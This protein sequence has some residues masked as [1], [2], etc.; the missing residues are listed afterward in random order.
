MLFWQIREWITKQFKEGST[1]AQKTVLSCTN[2]TRLEPA[3]SSQTRNKS[4]KEVKRRF[5][6]TL[7]RVYPQSMSH[8]IFWNFL[9][10]PVSLLSLHYQFQKQT[11]KK[12]WR[13][14]R[15]IK[16][17]SHL[18]YRQENVSKNKFKSDQKKRVSKLNYWSLHC[19]ILSFYRW[20]CFRIK[21]GKKHH[22]FQHV[23]RFQ[24][25]LEKRVKD[26]K[27]DTTG[28]KANSMKTTA[29]YNV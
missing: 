27:S 4:N 28:S 13:E 26:L 3:Q 22:I 5:H 9:P 10:C 23:Y 2:W 11:L 1:K 24:P 14:S 15:Q 17:K 29:L 25:E 12:N 20:S 8:F 16:E 21:S 6:R 7:K 19:E 18:N